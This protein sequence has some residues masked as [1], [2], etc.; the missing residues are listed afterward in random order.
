MTPPSSKYVFS[1]CR[2]LQKQTLFLPS[3]KCRTS[4]KSRGK[5]KGKQND[6]PDLYALLG[7]QHERW[8]ATDAQIKLGKLKAFQA[9][10]KRKA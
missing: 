7:L 4:W 10:H 6:R 1:P 8:M 2:K 3:L 5:K 9:L